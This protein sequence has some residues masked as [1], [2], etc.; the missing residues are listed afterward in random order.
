MVCLCGRVIA[1]NTQ[2][3]LDNNVLSYLN[4][5]RFP[6][7]RL[8]QVICADNAF[9][10]MVESLRR[11]EARDAVNLLRSCFLG[12][13][14]DVVVLDKEEHLV[15][16]LT[17]EGVLLRP[18]PLVPIYHIA[19]ALVDGLLWRKVIAYKFRN[20]PSA[21]PPLQN[22]GKSL[23]VLNAVTQSLKCLDKDLVCLAPSRPYKS[24]KVKVGGSNCIKV[25]RE[26]IYATELM[27]ILSNWLKTHD[28][29]TVNGQWHLQT[30]V[31]KHK[32]EY[33]DIVLRRD[34]NPPTVLEPLATGD[35]NFVHLHIEKI[36]EYMALLKA[37][38][39]WV[40]HFTCEDNHD[41]VW[42]SDMELDNG[43]NVVH[44]C[45]NLEFTEVSMMARW[46]DSTHV[47][48]LDNQTIAM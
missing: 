8:H 4:W 5:V 30:P 25:P 9:R 33:T 32:L 42:Q 48:Q 37:N 31:Q 20:A 43:V 1:S 41:P 47:T 27:R 21:E 19:S 22:S 45:H 40:I 26:S 24:S 46:K 11:D 34:D 3:L 36:T 6:V 39:A 28:G 29:W 2:L 18:D 23:H 14:G 10:S 17:S 13:P 38:E 12:F 35:R 44:L 16:F 15:D 7:E